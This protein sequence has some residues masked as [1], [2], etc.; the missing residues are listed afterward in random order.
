[1]CIYEP[2]SD[3]DSFY[4]NFISCRQIKQLYP[5]H[6]RPQSKLQLH[7]RV[8]AAIHLLSPSPL[9]RGCRCCIIVIA[10]V[11]VFYLLLFTNA[12]N[13]IF[14][15]IIKK[16]QSVWPNIKANAPFYIFNPSPFT[17]GN[18]TFTVHSGPLIDRLGLEGTYVIALSWVS[19]SYDFILL[20]K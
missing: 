13:T 6:M 8:I 19:L 12:L 7:Y 15:C 10:V 20:F 4:G 1:M 9:S 11:N 14:N 3:R 16:R 5:T 18:W 17:N 2:R